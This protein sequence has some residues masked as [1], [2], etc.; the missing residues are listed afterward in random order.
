MICEK[1]CSLLYNKLHD[2]T[3]RFVASDVIIQHDEHPG[4]L[5]NRNKTIKICMTQFRKFIEE[6]KRII[7]RWIVHIN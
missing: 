5:R 4:V 1:V 3:T 6:K 2:T 7:I